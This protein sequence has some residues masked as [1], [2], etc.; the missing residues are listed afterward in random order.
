M[1]RKSILIGL[2]VLKNNRTIGELKSLQG[3][4]ER[5][6][7]PSALFLGGYRRHREMEEFFTWAVTGGTGVNGLNTHYIGLNM[8]TLPRSMTQCM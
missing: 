3:G 8:T 5:Q 1:L 2:L 6:L 4:K 7:S